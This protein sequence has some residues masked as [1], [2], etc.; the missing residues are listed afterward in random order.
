MDRTGADFDAAYISGGAGMSI[1]MAATQ[2]EWVGD[3]AG[4]NDTI[5]GGLGSDTC[6]QNSGTGPLRSCEW[7]NPLKACPVP[8]GTITDS[9]GD[10]RSGGRT[11]E[12]VD[13]IA[14]RG[15]P[16]NATFAGKMENGYNELGGKT[17]YV[18][19]SQGYSYN[20]HL[21]KRANERKVQAG[22]VIGFVG[23]TGN[24]QGGTPHLH[25]E[26]HP[27]DGEAVDPYRYL[28]K[29]CN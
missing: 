23:T 20:A 12:G 1:D 16:V 27:N 14:K 10:P 22:D 6:R 3:F 24:A 4:G 25:F 19:G 11:H 29:V 18:H 26:W 28:V 15:D 7:P 5:S 8:G 9:F 13:I 17:V 21:S 2:F